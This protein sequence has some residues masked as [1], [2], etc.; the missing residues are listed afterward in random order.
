MILGVPVRKSGDHLNTGT[1]VEKLLAYANGKI[2]AAAEL[3]DDRWQGILPEVKDLQ[4]EMGKIK[5]ALRSGLE[6]QEKELSLPI[7]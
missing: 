4:P 1:R 2:Y 7:S 5:S 3:K 6:Y